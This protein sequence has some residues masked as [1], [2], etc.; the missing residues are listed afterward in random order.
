MSLLNPST[1]NF[2][3]SFSKEFYNEAID[4]K[5]SDYLFHANNPVKDI[6]SLIIE[7]FQSV[8]VSGIE[9]Q[10]IVVPNMGGSNGFNTPY[11]GTA[12]ETDILTTSFVTITSR[13]VMLNWARML[14]FTKAYYSR[15]RTVKKFDMSIMFLDTSGSPIM[16]FDYTNCYIS[17]IP[18]LTFSNTEQFNDSKTFDV[19][20]SFERMK[21]RFN[22]P[23]FNKKNVVLI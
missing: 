18:E 6:G 15:Q 17:G 16:I 19:K 22:I 12:N 23:T 11:A 1:S 13:N 2:N 20:I 10:E 8:T 4:K 5:Y 21:T 14:E 7:S 9:F 3:I